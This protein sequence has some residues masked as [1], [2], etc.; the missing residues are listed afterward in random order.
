MRFCTAPPGKVVLFTS[1]APDANPFTFA[2]MLITIQCHQPE[3]D[4]ASGSYTVTAKLLVSLGAPLHLSAGDLFKPEQPN[5][6]NS[7]LF[8]TLLLAFISGLESLKSEA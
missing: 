1:P 7:K 4:G 6:L 5:P 8:G 2:G 3:P